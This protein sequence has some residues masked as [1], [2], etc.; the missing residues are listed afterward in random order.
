M[1]SRVQLPQFIEQIASTPSLGTL[2]LTY[3][4]F[5]GL[6]I[7]VQAN[8]AKSL[9]MLCLPNNP[10]MYPG[11]H[12]K[13][14]KP[15]ILNNAEVFPDCELPKL[16]I[17]VMEDGE[18]VVIYKIVNE[19][20]RRQGKQYLVHWIGYNHKHKASCLCPFYQSDLSV[21][22]NPANFQVCSYHQIHILWISE[23]A[24]KMRQHMTAW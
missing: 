22:S 3:S 21:V 23:Q 19:H 20:V 13:L 18:E 5:N 2:A 17:V 14:L 12:T 10:K 16:G 8:S 24:K 11:F 9:Y 1:P 6:Y 15:F 7:V 4:P